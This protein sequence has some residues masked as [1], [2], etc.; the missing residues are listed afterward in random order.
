M[1]AAAPKEVS[2]A[3]ASKCSL[4]RLVW[5][6]RYQQL[7]DVLKKKKHDPEEV[8][9]R[10]RTPLMLSVTLGHLE[11]TRVLLKFGTNVNVINKSGWT[12]VQEAV[13]TGDPELLQVGSLIRS[14]IAN[15]HY[16]PSCSWFWKGA[17]ASA[18]RVALAAFQSC[19]KN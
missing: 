11:S 5:D 7:D 19:C 9:P 3:G 1:A 14:V 18:T 6:N 8:D 4:H 16:P 13:A 2:D 12:V 10:G 15:F 17:I